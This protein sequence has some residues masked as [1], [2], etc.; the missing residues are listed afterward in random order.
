MLYGEFLRAMAISY[1]ICCPFA[2]ELNQQQRHRKHPFCVNY[3]S[4]QILQHGN[5][6]NVRLLPAFNI[7]F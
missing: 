3:S 1:L 2:K 4:M 6:L 5:M 7:N